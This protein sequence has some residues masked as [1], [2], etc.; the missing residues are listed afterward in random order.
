[1]SYS[2]R[3]GLI[4]IRSVRIF[5]LALFAHLYRDLFICFQIYL[6][7]ASYIGES[8]SLTCT[9]AR[10]VIGT[11]GSNVSYGVVSSSFLLWHFWKL[12]DILW[13]V[14]ANVEWKQNLC[15]FFLS[16]ISDLLYFS[17]AK[18]LCCNLHL[19]QREISKEAIT[20]NHDNECNYFSKSIVNF[21]PV[22]GLSKVLILNF[23]KKLV[24]VVIEG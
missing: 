19:P 17:C 9:H 3:Y 6:N 21:R 18:G 14:W 1:M 24:G 5:G 11:V 10:T 13:N 23:K 7:K 20:K 12:E 22:D 16:Y 2:I 4:F 15:L 8:I